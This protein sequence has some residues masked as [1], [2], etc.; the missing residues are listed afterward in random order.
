MVCLVDGAM[1]RG[2]EPREPFGD[3][4]RCFLGVVQ[5]VV[6]GLALAL[7]LRRQAVEALGAAIRTGQEQIAERTCDAAVAIIE[8]VQG[9]PPQMREPGPR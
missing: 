7:D 8:R 6:V 2:E 9:D 5:N 3:N 1:Q 4:Q